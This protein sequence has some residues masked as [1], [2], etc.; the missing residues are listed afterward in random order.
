MNEWMADG[1]KKQWLFYN[2][3]DLWTNGVWMPMNM[4]FAFSYHV[5]SQIWSS[6]SQKFNIDLAMLYC[7]DSLLATPVQYNT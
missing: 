6:A 2:I 7:K 3:H 1:H 4:P 5:E